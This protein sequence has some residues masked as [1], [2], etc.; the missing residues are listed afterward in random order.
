MSEDNPRAAE[1]GSDAVEA[2]SRAWER[3]RPDLPVDSIGIVTRVWQAAKVLGDDRNRMSTRELARAARISA[4]AITQRVDRAQARGLVKRMPGSGPR[5]VDV[6]LTENGVEVIDALVEEVLVNESD[7]LA[8][9]PTQVRADLAKN[10]TLLLAHLD[11]VLGH[12][13]PGQVGDWTSR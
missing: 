7:L 5:A 9:L 12:S 4:G 3:E 13:E 10:L 8:G 6:E 11:E 1:T 2:I